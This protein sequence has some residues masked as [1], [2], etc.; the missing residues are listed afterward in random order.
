MSARKQ[1]TLDRQARRRLGIRPDLIGVVVGG[2][3]HHAEC[4]AS[5]AELTAAIEDEDGNVVVMKDDDWKD[6]VGPC[7]GCQSLFAELPE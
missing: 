2:K 1:L 4:F 3:Y 5:E 6:S 7:A